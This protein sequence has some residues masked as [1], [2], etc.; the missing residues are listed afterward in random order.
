[1]QNAQFPVI[2][3]PNNCKINQQNPFISL[4]LLKKEIQDIEQ[5]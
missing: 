1:M 2:F 4:S 3:A 5:K